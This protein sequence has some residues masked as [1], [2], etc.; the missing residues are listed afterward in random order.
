[1]M[2]II[3]SYRALAR[4]TWRF[5]A[6]A[7]R[8]ATIAASRRGSV[9]TGRS[10]SSPLIG[11]A[12]HLVLRAVE[13]RVVYWEGAQRGTV[14]MATRKDAFVASLETQVAP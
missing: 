5:T 9:R 4:L 13:K 14:L 6:D 1:M 2:S 11:L 10:I 12:A 8:A 3:C 7:G